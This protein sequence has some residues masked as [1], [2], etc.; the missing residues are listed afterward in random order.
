MHADKAQAHGTT[1]PN[2]RRIIV[3]TCN[4]YRSWTHVTLHV[5][6]EIATSCPILIDHQSFLPSPIDPPPVHHHGCQ[7]TLQS[8]EDPKRAHSRARAVDEIP[9]APAVEPRGGETTDEERQE[10][11][12]RQR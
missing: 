4:L 3:F 11:A 1:K 2:W 6:L 9:E 5:G 8:V 10:R 7:H 12:R